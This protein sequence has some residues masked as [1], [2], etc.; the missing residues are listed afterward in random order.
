MASKKPYYLPYK[1]TLLLAWGRNF[2]NKL[3]PNIVTWGVPEDEFDDL[4]VKGDLFDAAQMKA[5]HPNAGKTDRF[6]RNVKAKAF[7]N[8][9]RDLVNAYLRN[10]K[11]LTDQDRMD[12]GIPIPDKTR[13]KIDVP[14]SH[15]VIKLRLVDSGVIRADFKDQYSES[16]AKP[17][18]TNGAM[19]IFAV[20][21][22]SPVD[23]SELQENVFVT[24]TP[25]K[26]EFED[27]FRN[28][29]LY[30]AAAWQN[31]KGKRGRW[32]DIQ[33]IIIP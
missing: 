19:F 31:E 11:K 14:N 17:Y 20:L 22:T 33:S 1:H 10:N 29:T 26:F 23:H 3:A 12:L 7:K 13:T 30:V 9:A 8:A 6:D 21:D 24:R 15:P 2:I 16:K 4:K 5:E 28:H 18:G 27:K 32:S 25:Y